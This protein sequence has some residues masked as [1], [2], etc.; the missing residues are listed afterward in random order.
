MAGR[1]AGD[2]INPRVAAVA[3]RTPVRTDERRPSSRESQCV[4]TYLYRQIDTRRRRGRRTRPGASHMAAAADPMKGALSPRTA[5]SAGE[6]HGT[7]VGGFAG[8][9]TFHDGITD[10]RARRQQS[11][12][13]SPIMALCANPWPCALHATG[14]HGAHHGSHDRRPVTPDPP[15]AWFGAPG[16]DFEA[17]PLPV[18]LLGGNIL[19]ARSTNPGGIA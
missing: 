7:A 4:A 13:A 14:R 12:N 9:D 6:H 11:S 2:G 15:I 19:A 3:A 18:I 5:G 8:Q 1:P 17:H 10:G 16:Q